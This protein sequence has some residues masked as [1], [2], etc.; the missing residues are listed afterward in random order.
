MLVAEPVH[1]LFLNRGE[2]YR[3]SHPIT[4][5]DECTVLDFRRD[6][7]GGCMRGG[8][9]GGRSSERAVRHHAA[10]WNANAAGSLRG[11]SPDGAAN[12][13]SAAEYATKP[14]TIRALR[15]SVDAVSTQ[16]KANGG[17]SDAA[18]DTVVSFIEH[19]GEHYGQLAMYCRLNAIVP[20]ASRG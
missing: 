16:L 14:V 13:L 20:P 18:A 4:G 15:D 2:P 6:S 1:A 7:V 8:S 17:V 9:A 19:S 12:E 10:F 5:G 3:V 11:E